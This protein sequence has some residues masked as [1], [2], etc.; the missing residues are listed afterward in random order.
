[1]PRKYL[2]P[3]LQGAILQDL[4]VNSKSERQVA[5]DTNTTKS[6]VHRTGKRA[7]KRYA[8]EIDVTTVNIDKENIPLAK[9]LKTANVILEVKSSRLKKLTIADKHKLIK[10]VTTN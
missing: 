10:Y 2:N 4:F 7:L 3:V 8:D 5:K 9:I 6:T 1:M